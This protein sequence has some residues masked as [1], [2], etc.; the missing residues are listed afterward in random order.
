MMLIPGP[1]APGGVRDADLPALG[2]RTESTLTASL[3]AETALH[4]GLD[5]LRTDVNLA[6]GETGA[7]R[8]LGDDARRPA[9]DPTNNV[10]L[11]DQR[12]LVHPGSGSLYGLYR[13]SGIQACTGGVKNADFLEPA[14]SI[15][16]YLRRGV[17]AGSYA[18]LACT[19]TSPSTPRLRP[20]RPVSRR[21]RP[22]VPQRPSAS[23]VV[24]SRSSSASCRS[25]SRKRMSRARGRRPGWS[26]RGLR[27]SPACACARRPWRSAGRSRCRR[28]SCGHPELRRG[29]RRADGATGR[30][31]EGVRVPAVD[32]RA[33]VG[34]SPGGTDL[35]GGDAG[36]GARRAGRRVGARGVVL[37][38]HRVERVDRPAP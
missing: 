8:D 37:A 19:S 15:F 16:T 1:R 27:P 35:R 34:R 10:T 26:C 2:V 32:R 29:C 36:D 24:S 21:R 9:C 6:C 12:H 14:S 7:E 25:H 18:C 5:K 38:A 31:R 22:R 11:D 23:D 13:V 3:E 20:A 4:T 17:P 28:G 33:R 30:A